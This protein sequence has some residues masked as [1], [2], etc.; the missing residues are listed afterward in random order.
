MEENQT[1]DAAGRE[2]E[3]IRQQQETRNEIVINYVQMA[4]FG[5]VLVANL[6]TH[7]LPVASYRA[8]A[9]LLGLFAASL[10]VRV[11]IFFYLRSEP[12]YSLWRKY[13]ISTI[14]LAIFTAGPFLMAMQGAYPWLFLRVFAVC[15]Y[16][17]L[18][19]LAGLRYSRRVVVFTGT[20]TVVLH[21]LLFALPAEEEYR[22][23]L[24]MI[25]L[26]TLGITT[27]CTAYCVESLIRI[28]RE[29]ALKEQLARFLPPELVEQI[30]R[31]PDLLDQKT[32]RRMATVIFTDIRG[33]THFSEKL[34]A[35]QVV[36]FLN[37][38]LEEMTVAIMDHLRN[39]G[40]V[41]RRRRDGGLWRSCNL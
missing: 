20:A 18:I 9:M 1:G 33:F 13:L 6:L 29:A 27:L 30:S 4:H 23:P 3:Q 12:I 22:L 26:L 24:L 25:G 5:L 7:V 19:V 40:Q 28:H 21:G 32:Q 41:H 17:L 11:S 37:A 14:D 31:Q 39:A 2:F 10:L 35:E 36:K 8:G 16:T 15:I 34:P 38:F